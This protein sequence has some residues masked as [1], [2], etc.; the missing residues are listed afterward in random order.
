MKIK[1]EFKGRTIIK[2]DSIM[3]EQR[4]VVDKLEPSRFAFYQSIGLGYIFEPESINYT[5][6]EQEPKKEPR[7]RR[8]KNG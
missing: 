2:Y 6:I 1:D 5:G 4:I 8:K 7:K 3:G